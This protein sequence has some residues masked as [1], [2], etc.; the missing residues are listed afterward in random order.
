MDTILFITVGG[1][2][3]PIITAVETLKPERVIF[4]C[5]GGSLSL[6][7]AALD[8][9]MSLYLTTS[10]VREN[11]FRVERG[12]STSRAISSTVTIE[13]TLSQELPRFL[14]QYNYGGAMVED[15]PQGPSHS[16]TPCSPPTNYPATSAAA[17]KNCRISA[18]ASTPGTVSTTWKPGP[19]FP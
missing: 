6:G 9:G 5:S 16:S 18:P 3:S 13:R 8:Y 14:Q 1:S 15:R 4:I 19:C 7:A 11:L 17:F 10:R 12:Q 2:P